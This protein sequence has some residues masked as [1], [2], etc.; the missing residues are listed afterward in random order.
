MA[1]NSKRAPRKKTGTDVRMVANV[2]QGLAHL[3]VPVSR[4]HRDRQNA[5]LHP[6]RNID[7]LRESLAGFKQLKPVVIAQDGTVLAGNGTLEA[8][9]ALGWTHIAAVEFDGTPAQARDYAVLDNRTGELSSWDPA[10]LLGQLD[11]RANLDALDASAADGVLGFLPAE[12]DAIRETAQTHAQQYRMRLD[13][14]KPHPRNYREHP[15]DQIAHLMESLRAHG[16]YR[17]IVVAGDGTILAG[18]GLA[19]AAAKLGYTTAPVIRLAI[20]ADDPRALK[21]LAADNELPK[22]AESDDRALSELL[23]DVLESGVGL[24]G[25]GYDAEQ[26]AA[27]VFVTRPATEVPNE[28]AAAAWV[29]MPEF[30]ASKEAHKLVVNFTSE[31]EREAFLQQI[32]VSVIGRKFGATWSCWW[33]P[34]TEKDDL[35][36]VKFAPGDTADR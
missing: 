15:D 20:T 4:L 11:V 34:R 29:G 17:S 28:D 10:A 1:K 18:H 25:T 5:R 13:E 14:L 23:K 21:I 9:I 36:A 35:I 26:L 8:A 6:Q 24:L 12:V 30:R 31:K 3:L 27:L 33:P 19:K 16:F 2:N 22:L 7:L 32:G